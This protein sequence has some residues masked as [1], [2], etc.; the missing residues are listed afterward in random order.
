MDGTVVW[1]LNS[2]CISFHIVVTF[3]SLFIKK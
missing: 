3:E 1:D 2:Q